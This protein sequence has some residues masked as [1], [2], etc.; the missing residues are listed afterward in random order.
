MNTAIT[1]SDRQFA[2][3]EANHRFLNTLTALAGLLRTD[4]ADFADPAVRHAVRVFSSHI[5]AFAGMHR[6]LGEPAG[7]GQVDAQAHFL[8]L[9]TD[10][11]AAHLAPRGVFC[12]FSADAGT[13][14]RQ[15]CQ[16]LSLI[17]VELVTNAA[18]HAFVG[19]A[20]GRIRIE[21]RRA[22]GAWT[23]QVADDGAGMR[24]RAA[25]TPGGDGMR[26]VRELARSLGATLLVH[27]D[28]GGVT[29]S[30]YLPYE[31]TPVSVTH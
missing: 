14:P 23:C 28:A 19:R 7:E 9:S 3:R 25:G 31:P 18:K 26:L 20:S 16:T 22:D 1:E 17:V 10:L 21:L 27:S 30:L 12:D 11:C 4:F 29:T 24:P 2:L 5:Q 15:T 8:K 6:T 13:L